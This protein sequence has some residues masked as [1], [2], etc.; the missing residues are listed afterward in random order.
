MKTAFKILGIITLLLGL[1]CGQLIPTHASAKNDVASS[2]VT[3]VSTPIF[4]KN[5][6]VLNNQG[7]D[8]T[9]E[10]KTSLTSESSTIIIKF[11]SN[12]QNA[13]QSLFGISNKDTGFR[14]N[15]FSFFMRNNGELGVEVRDANNSINYLISR[16]ASLWG[17]DQNGEVSNTIAFVSNSQQGTYTLYANGDKIIENKTSIFKPINKISGANSFVIGGVNREGILDY[18]FQGIVES[19]KIYNDPLSHEQLIT[20]TTNATTNKMIFKAGDATKANYFRI[21]A[22]YTLSNGRVLASAD[23]RYGGTHDS[24]SKI[25]IAT[26]FSDDNGVTWSSPTLPL[27]FDDYAEQT[28]DWPRDSVGKNI[29][30]SGSASFIDS[31]IVE[32]KLTKKVILMADFMPAGIGNNN[33]LK[34][35]SGY[36]SINGKYYLKLKYST[37]SAYNY[38]IRENGVI[39]NDLS[40]TPTEYSVDSYYNI[41]KN[42][43]YLN[44]EQYSVKFENGNLIEYKN[45]TFVKMNIFYKDSLFKLTPT[46]YIGYT[47]STNSGE[48]WNAPVLL[49]PFLGLNHNASYLGP[50]QGLVVS[51]TNRIIF[52]TY[53]SNQ[54]V[55]LISDDNGKTWSNRNA[56]LPFTGATA[57]A[58]MVE[59]KPGVI[60][61]YLRTTT[62]K[63]GYMTSLD[64]GNTW[65]AVQYLD[66]VQ[67]TS[68]GTQLSIIKYSQLINGR[69]A[70]I[71]STPNSTSGRRAGQLWVGYINKT[72]NTIEW[73]KKYDVD[74][75]QYGYSYS[76]IT[77]LPNHQIGLLYEKYDAWSRNE[78]HLKN[79]LKYTTLSISDIMK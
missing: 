15:Y 12:N 77:E 54:M 17:K 27:K 70:V 66:I 51:N 64:G 50:G 43:T 10:L 36:K 71:L 5:N 13:L 73:A 39:F 48:T 53:S 29:Q 79:V 22:L 32:D 59:L 19:L 16:P 52:A 7:L 3:A 78:L 28:I 75:P 21:P 41:K 45:G 47:T 44:V 61:T 67:N 63:I 25:N 49:P 65:S 31:A 68:Y 11:K 55:Y 30:I 6:I 18:K 20:E 33:A 69:E 23:A 34:T 62:G 38:S 74:Y 4:E 42:G 46:N 37:E 58:Q 9:N 8:V 40:N 76:A 60:Q 35:D 26:S 1:V 72:N 2:Q 57:E 14:N 24:R 56:P